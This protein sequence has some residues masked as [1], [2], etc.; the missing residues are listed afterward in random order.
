[1]SPVSR[2][3]ILAAWLTWVIA[4]CV[5]GERTL[6]DDIPGQIFFRPV[7]F[8]D[9]PGWRDDDWIADALSAF[10]RSCAKLHRLPPERPM[11]PTS[12]KKVAADWQR[13]CEV[14]PQ[15]ALKDDAVAREYLT[16]WFVPLRVETSNGRKG[17][18]TGYYEPQL[19]GKRGRSEEYAVPLY[20]LPA[21]LVNVNLEQ[22]GT[23]HGGSHIIGRVVKGRLMPYFV[24]AEIDAGAVAKQN[25]EL[26]WVSDAVDAFLLH[27]Q[28]SGRIV[29][30]DDSA[31]R[32]GFA[33]SNGFPF[34]AIGR[35]LI[36][37]GEIR[38][39]DLC[40]DSVRDWLRQHRARSQS[41]MQQ[42]GRYIFFREIGSE[43]PVGAQGVVLTPRRSLAVDPDYYPL[44]APVWLDTTWPNS[45]KPL[46]RLVVAQD[47]GGAIKGP[48]R[49]D[50]FWGTGDEALEHAKCMKQE[51]ESYILVPKSKHGNI[52]SN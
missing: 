41:L 13:V 28:G 9:L 50:L 35:V 38:R 16:T 43:G 47:V 33:G 23:P 36:A 2:L 1:M 5:G 14:L 27:I 22:F 17:L 7:E 34:V 4:L 49:G 20:R 12:L 42:N 51:F 29:F 44:G 45:Q 3:R 31:V 25:L 6:S 26:I 21:D 46:R 10:E 52:Y 11:N 8:H 24:R 18:V 37:E 19:K 32:I 48:M 40:M 39:E 30:P 15:E